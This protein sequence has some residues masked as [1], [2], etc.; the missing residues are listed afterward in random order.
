VKPKGGDGRR[1]CAAPP[2][3][4]EVCIAYQFPFPLQPLG[5]GR[6]GEVKRCGF[7]HH[8][9]RQCACCGRRITNRLLGGYF[10][11]SALTGLLFCYRCADCP[12]Q[13]LLP[14]RGVR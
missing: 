6:N 12:P 5:N 14:L 11:R 2:K 3:T 13:L 7:S 10:G 9:R 4:N 1:L 8:E